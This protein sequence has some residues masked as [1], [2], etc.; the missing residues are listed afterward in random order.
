MTCSEDKKIELDPGT[1][2]TN[3]LNCHITCHYPCGIP[4][5]QDKSGCAA[6]SNGKC[7]KCQCNCIWSDHVNNGYRIEMEMVPE[8]RTYDN[9]KL[10]YHEAKSGMS[11][12]A[13]I[14]KKMEEELRVLHEAVLGMVQEARKVLNRLKEIALKP[15]P[16]SEVDILI[17]SEKHE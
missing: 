17:E 14:V 15:D 8:E 7:V 9:L 1:Y 6:M 2:V 4:R 5:D 3:C 10:R 16:L 12:S 13:N 11:A